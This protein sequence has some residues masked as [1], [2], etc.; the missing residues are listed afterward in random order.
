[1]AVLCPRNWECASLRLYGESGQVEQE[2]R[3]G[4]VGGACFGL[5]FMQHHMLVITARAVDWQESSITS[6]Y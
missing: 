2:K 4:G 3:D 6:K 1:M 5:M